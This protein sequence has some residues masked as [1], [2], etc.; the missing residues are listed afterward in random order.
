MP[1]VPHRT[2]YILASFMLEPRSSTLAWMCLWVSSW[3]STLGRSVPHSARSSLI[4]N[5]EAQVSTAHS[6]L[7]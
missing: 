3:D 1:G 7:K 4:W 5:Q 6:A 2:S